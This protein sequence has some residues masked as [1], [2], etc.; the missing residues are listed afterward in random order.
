MFCL[1]DAMLEEE[2]LISHNG[3]IIDA[4]FVDVPRQRN[5]RDDNKKIKE[6]EVQLYIYAAI[7]AFLLI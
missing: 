6:G 5:N 2:G 3:T 4:T 1:F 7:S